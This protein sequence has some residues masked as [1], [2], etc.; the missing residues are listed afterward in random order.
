MIRARF[1]LLLGVVLATAISV[2]LFCLYRAS[3]V[4]PDF[5][6]QNLRLDALK[7]NSG[8]GNWSNRCCSST[9]RCGRAHAG[10]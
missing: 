3:L 6:R 5:Y 1:L 8:A 7:R 2:G 4:V 10:S 9:T